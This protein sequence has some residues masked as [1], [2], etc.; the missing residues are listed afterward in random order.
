MA[1][2]TLTVTRLPFWLAPATE[3]DWEAIYRE[4]MPRVYN[5][6]RYRVGD[7]PEAEDLTSATFER[8]WR[9]RH[10]Y[11]RDL[12]GFSTWIFAIARNLA[13]DHYRARRP[14]LPLEAAESVAED[15]TPDQLAV[16]RSDCDRL[17]RLLAG[18]NE[19]ERDLIALKYGS[20]LTHRMIAR[21]TGLTESNVGTILHRAI[22]TLRERWERKER[23]DG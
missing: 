12:A 4:Q 22:V 14:H 19:R 10:R 5:F 2:E 15:A 16:A 13:I 18:L 7:G 23:G 6:F 9:A 3:A 8:A 17:L 1:T 11:R 21:A 20:G